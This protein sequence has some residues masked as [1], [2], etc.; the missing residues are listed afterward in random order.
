ML[1]DT[2]VAQDLGANPNGNDLAS[3]REVPGD[4]SGEFSI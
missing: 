2:M 1:V 4:V 3:I